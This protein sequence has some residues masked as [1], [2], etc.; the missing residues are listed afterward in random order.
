[1]NRYTY[2]YLVS[3]NQSCVYNLKFPPGGGWGRYC[4][5]LH[6][7]HQRRRGGEGAVARVFLLKYV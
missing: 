5:D 7:T 2:I 3:V 4:T 1:M 6:N